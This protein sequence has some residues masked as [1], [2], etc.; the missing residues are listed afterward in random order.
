M[1][2]VMEYYTFRFDYEGFE[3][4]LP[5][6]LAYIKSECSSYVIFDEVAEKTKKLH[7]QGKIKPVK[8]VETFRRNLLKSFPMFNRSNYSIAPVKKDTY[9]IYITKDGKVVINNLW[10]QEKIEEL[11]KAYVK[12]S[13]F[14]E[15]MKEKKPNET[16]SQRIANEMEKEIPSVINTYINLIQFESLGTEEFSSS[17]Y[18]VFRQAKHDMLE[19]MLDRM[20]KAVKTLS[21]SVINGLFY[22][23]TNHFLMKSDKRKEWVSKIFNKLDNF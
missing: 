9:D 13:E 14:K 2:I 5:S 22:G 18:Q 20:G 17:Q 6:L 16:W 11:Q 19:F 23:I 15:V 21:K 10:S 4:K 1:Y 12:P 3:E 7:Y 8:S